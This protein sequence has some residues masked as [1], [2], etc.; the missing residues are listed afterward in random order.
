MTSNR[1]D[2]EKLNAAPLAEFA[3]TRHHSREAGKVAVVNCDAVR[4]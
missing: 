2:E 3:R 1:R 4:V